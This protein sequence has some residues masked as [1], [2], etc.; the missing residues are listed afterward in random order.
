MAYSKS[1]YP[2]QRELSLE[3]NIM[4]SAIYLK[5]SMMNPIEGTWHLNINHDIYLWV[6][7]PDIYTTGRN[8]QILGSCME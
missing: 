8:M 6:Q 7:L 1:R 4:A 2:N 5:F 3:Y